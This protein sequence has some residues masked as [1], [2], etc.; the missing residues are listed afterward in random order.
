MPNNPKISVIM[1]VYN[2]E[3]YLREAIGS[4]LNQTFTD[5][6]FIIVNDGSTDNSLEIIQSY[7]DERIKIINNETNIGLTKS[8][9]KALK[10]ARGECI[11][12][13]DA[14]DVSLP[15]RF[16]EQMKYFEWHPETVV[17]GTSKY[18]INEDGKILRKEIASSNPHKNLFEGNAFTHGSVMFKKEVVEE[19][20]YYNELFRY[21]QDYEFWLRIAKHYKVSNLTQ[22]LY[23][24]RSH[25]E[26]IR[27][28]NVE[29][30]ILY[31]LL[32]Q[33]LI[34]NALNAEILEKIK[35]KGIFQLYQYLE[36]RERATFHKVLGHKHAKNNN[37]L[38][39]REEYKKAFKLKPLDMRNNL[40]ILL[41]FLG[42]NLIERTHE[43]YAL[44]RSTVNNYFLRH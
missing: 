7:D 14:D 19:L 26:N 43:I 44:F 33:Q 27:V 38:L 4:I 23:K 40:H 11:A 39:A 35:N 34:K 6:E 31:H 2:G 20:G 15:N 37:L 13:Q 3:K 28:T 32:A 25:E 24:L 42:G 5:F 8:L 17:L 10:Q 36:T 18:V 9:N 12:R 21:S 16:E 1:S 41:S 30:A 29:E 22:P